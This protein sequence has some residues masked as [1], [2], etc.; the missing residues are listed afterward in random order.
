MSIIMFLAARCKA[1]SCKDYCHV[2]INTACTHMYTQSMQIWNVHVHM[3][4]YISM[5]TCTFHI[6]CACV[7]MYCT[8]IHVQY[9]YTHMCPCT[10]MYRNMKSASVLVKSEMGDCAI[11]NLGFALILDKKQTSNIAKV[12][13]M[14]ITWTWSSK[15]LEC[16]IATLYMHTP[17][18][19]KTQLILGFFSLKIT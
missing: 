12:S 6:T 2:H 9:M 16:Y 10:C 4:I 13:Y 18:L 15:Q 1:S 11:S 3:L 7:Y 8:C 14:T 19:P 17:V 5:C